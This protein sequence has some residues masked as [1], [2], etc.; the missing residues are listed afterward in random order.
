MFLKSQPIHVNVIAHIEPPHSVKRLLKYSFESYRV[1]DRT[2][3]WFRMTVENSARIPSNVFEKIKTV[4]NW[5][6]FGQFRLFLESQLYDIDVIAHIGPPNK[7]K[8]L[9][10]YSFESLRQFVKKIVTVHNWRFLG[11]FWLCFSNPSQ[12]MLMSLHT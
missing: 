3:I 9:L 7:V 10:K 6:I 1:F 2:S 12:T 5:L 8:R 4:H 11:H